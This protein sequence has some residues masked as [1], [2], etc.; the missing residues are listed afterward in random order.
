MIGDTEVFVG[1][2]LIGRNSK[3]IFKVIQDRDGE[4]GVEGYS[5]RDDSV[6]LASIQVDMSF[7][8]RTFKNCEIIGTIHDPGAMKRLEEC[9]KGK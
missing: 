4:I 1:D 6:A 9:W 3:C 7:Q 2:V 5:Q 8:F